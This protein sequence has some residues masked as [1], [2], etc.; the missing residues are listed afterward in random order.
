MIGT[1]IMD[2]SHAEMVAAVQFYLNRSVFDSDTVRTYH[3]ATVVRVHQRTNGRFVIE[4]DGRPE[5]D[6]EKETP[7]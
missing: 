2:I 1:V 6:E 3:K 7:K 5:P 4:F